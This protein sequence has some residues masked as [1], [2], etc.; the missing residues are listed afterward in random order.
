MMRPRSS[1]LPLALGLGLS[2]ALGAAGCSTP[3]ASMDMGGDN[4]KGDP[5]VLAGTFAITLVPP[6][7][8]TGTPGFTSVLGKVYDGATPSPIIWN[9]SSKA[10][11]CR[12]RKPRV[13]FCN[14]PC[15]GGAICVADDKCQRYPTAQSVGAV[16]VTGL[17]TQA[18]MT[19]FSMT[20]VAGA[21]QLPAGVSCPF[22][23]F[24]EGAAI[25]FETAGGAYA[26]FTLQTTGISPLTLLNDQ[27]PLAMNQALTLRWTPPGQAAGAKVLI[28][29]DISHHGGTKG[30][31]ECEADDTGSVE[32]A[33]ALITELLDLGAAG[34]PTV[35]VTR[36][37]AVGTALIA[38]GRVELSVSSGVEHPVQVPGITSCNDDKD[39]PMGQT[40]QADLTCK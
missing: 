39:C 31:I 14:S 29:L 26:P 35:V 21:Y 33:A 32:I 4:T 36:R 25:Q 18:G 23:A 19:E 5:S 22:P 16:R 38:P 11:P 40:C 37:S 6:V 20:Q 7:T 2:G 17:R 15:T 34:F 9:E 3:P 1:L 30:A 28:K 27:I 12:L 13:P 24:S 10:G 8:Q